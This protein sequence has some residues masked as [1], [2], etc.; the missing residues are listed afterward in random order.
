[1]CKLQRKIMID[2]K[3][4]FNG[5]GLTDTQLEMLECIIMCKAPDL[6]Y[7]LSKG[8]KMSIADIHEN[9][10]D[11]IMDH[12]KEVGLDAL[13][14]LANFRQPGRTTAMGPGELLMVMFVNDARF[15]KPTEDS[16]VVVGDLH[17]EMK[18]NACRMCGQKTNFDAVEAYKYTKWF[19]STQY[20]VM[21]DDNKPNRSIRG[22][23]Q[24]LEC[25][26]DSKPEYL[27]RYLWDL[28]K[29]IDPALNNSDR[30]IWVNRTQK[31]LLVE[32]RTT[33]VPDPRW[34]GRGKNRHF[35]ENHVKIKKIPA[36]KSIGKVF[37]Q[38]Q[39]ELCFNRYAR[40]EQFNTIMTFDKETGKCRVVDMRN[41]N[42]WNV[43]ALCEPIF[44][45]TRGIGTGHQ[46][47]GPQAEIL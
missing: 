25:A 44:R 17:I 40:D 47:N 5:Y 45:F 8:R 18:G 3:N 10:F 46:D 19:A 2:I 34:V 37:I 4:I 42:M 41:V 29:I 33:T 28:A 24:F 6:L 32:P 20:K 36:S 11:D 38:A 15:A 26:L 27:A 39:G 21:L 43:H 14:L 1:M 7:E 30:M 9:L 22:M 23:C 12:Y 16:D 35:D 13:R 31:A